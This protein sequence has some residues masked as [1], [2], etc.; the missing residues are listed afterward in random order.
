[1][2]PSTQANDLSLWACVVLVAIVPLALAGLVLMNAGLGRTRSA[3]HSMLAS[4]AAMA[5]AALVYCMIGFSWE[6]IAGGP[7]HSLML[8]GR[9]WDWIAAAPFCLRGLPPAATRS[10]LQ[11]LLQVFAVALAA[12]IP[13]SAGADRWRISASCFS[14]ALLA[15]WTYPLFAHWVWGGG[16]L[17]Q[18]GSSYGLG[19]GFIDSGGASTIQVVGG[20]TALSI[21]WIIGPRRGKFAQDGIAPAIPGHNI[22]YV[23]FGALLIVPGWI[24]LNAAGAILF[25]GAGAGQTPLIAINTVLSAAA[26]GLTALVITRFRFGKPDASLSANGWVSGLV[27]SSAV[28]AFVSP[29]VAIGTGLIAGGLAT[30]AVEL[31]ELR[32]GVDD[33]GG[34][35]SVHAVAGLWGLLAAGLFAGSE[36]G[37]LTAQLVGVATLLGVIL[38]LTYTLNWLLDRLRPQRT[39]RE[40]ERLG[41]DLHELGAGAYPEFMIHTDDFIER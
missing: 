23:L 2:T 33:P 37:Q 24:A 26:A 6:G 32:L 34:A 17:A 25:T 22:V 16:W 1:M 13:L 21:V 4:M 30:A 9:R 5:V 15:G 29:L 8:A 12:L 27:A 40:G 14:T 31:L 36:R 10:H 41:M 7:A 19:R 28:C 20:L 38:P 3:A 18:L 35:I 39:T 11:V